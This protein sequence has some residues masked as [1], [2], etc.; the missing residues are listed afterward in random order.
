M[1]EA[2]L[3]CRAEIMEAM[4]IKNPVEEGDVRDFRSSDEF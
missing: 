2:I 1:M 4:L 3:H